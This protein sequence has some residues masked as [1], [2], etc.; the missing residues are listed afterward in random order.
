MQILGQQKIIKMLNL[1]L[2]LVDLIIVRE[3]TEGFYADRNMA[4]GSGEFSP[5]PGVGLGFK[6][7]NSKSF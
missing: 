1:Y 3:N 7:N 6:K 5:V 2:K 4:E